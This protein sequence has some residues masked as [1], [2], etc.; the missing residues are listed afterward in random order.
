MKKAFL[1]LIL[2]FSNHIIF[3]QIVKD[4][5]ELDSINNLLTEEVKKII[6]KNV[7]EKETVFL[8]EAVHFSGTD[9]LAKTEFI[10]YLV[11]EHQYKDIAFESDFFA[12]L[13]DH[14]KSNLYPLWSKSNQCEELFDF[15]KKNNVTIWGFDNK[16]HSDY[17]RNNFTTKLSEILNDGGIKL[18]NEFIRI[19]NLIIAN[20]FDSRKILSQKEINYVRNYIVEIQSDEAIKANKLWYQI[21]ENFKTAIKLYTVKDNISHKNGI[22]IRDKQM[23]NNL[24]YL[25]KQN[26]NKKFIVW[27]ANGHM[28]K[29]NDESMEGQTMG[30]QFRELNPNSSYHIAV[31]SIRLPNRNEKSIIKASKNKNSILSLLPSLDINYFVDTKTLTSENISLGNKIFDD[32]YIFNLKSNKINLLN[33]FDALVFIAKGETVT[34]DSD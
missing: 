29:S 21:L 9:F 8:G 32:M 13:F 28:S 31:A 5:Y 10:K 19:T 20:Q 27:L 16:L 22:P 33:H 18:D 7:S 12:L 15:L 34:Y 26:V 17:S 24:D 30:Y 3:S 14:N 4:I 25:V 11:I 2:I 6:D 23:A 1:L